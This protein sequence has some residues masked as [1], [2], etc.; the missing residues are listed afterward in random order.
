LVAQV[1]QKRV[2]SC[3]DELIKLMPG[4]GRFHIYRESPI[5]DMDCRTCARRPISPTQRFASL[6]RPPHLR[7][8]SEERLRSSFRESF[9]MCCSRLD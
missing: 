5:R 1:E 7:R 9:W 8:S 6:E 2:M 3:A 4:S